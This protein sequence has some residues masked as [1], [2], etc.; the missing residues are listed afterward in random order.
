MSVFRISKLNKREYPGNS[1]IIGPTVA[2]TCSQSNTTCS[3][4]VNVCDACSRKAIL[5]TQYV[6]C[7]C[8]CCDCL[9]RCTCTSITRTVPS[10][11]WSITEQN[12]A[13][14][15][16]SWGDSSSCNT[17]STFACIINRGHTCCSNIQNL[18][19][20][21]LCTNGSGRAVLAGAQISV[22][23]ANR[24][25]VLGLNSGSGWFVAGWPQLASFATCRQYAGIGFWTN[26]TTG[27]P[28]GNYAFGISNYNGGTNYK[29]KY[30][31]CPVRAFKYCN[32]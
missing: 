2:T 23:W 16:D 25:N 17:P 18:N 11:I 3:S 31:T 29:A 4:C 15:R 22:P 32:Y 27:Y 13:K 20:T 12:E 5:G 28:G 8:A 19:C 6:A 26:C 24:N 9:Y 14:T 21:I 7:T 30:Y 1:N 10:G